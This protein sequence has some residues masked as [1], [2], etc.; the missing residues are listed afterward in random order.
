MS[1]R[2]INPKRDVPL[3]DLMTVFGPD[4]A[5][6]R[7]IPGYQLRDSQLAMAEAVQTALEQ[8][9]HLIAE[10]GT[11][12]GKTFAYLVPAILS[13]KKVLVS[14]GTRNLQDQLIEKDFPLI[15]D[16][17]K[18]PVQAAVLKGRANYLCLYRLEQAQ[19]HQGALWGARDQDLKTIQEWSEWTRSGD[20]SEVRNV[21]EDSPIWPQVTST[22]DNCLGQ[23]CP[24]IHDCHPLKARRKAQDVDVLIVNH[25]L[26]CA[27]WSLKDDGFGELLPDTDVVIIDEAHQLVETA[28]QFLGTALSARQFLLL[29]QDIIR[30][31]EN[32]ALDMPQVIDLAELL[33]QDVRELRTI[34]PKSSHRGQWQ[35]ALAGRNFGTALAQMGE[36]LGEMV[37]CLAQVAARSKGLESC[38]KRAADLKQALVAFQAGTETGWIQW[39][40]CYRTSFVFYRTP[41]DISQAFTDYAFTSAATWIFTSATLSV[42]QRFDFFTRRLGLDDAQAAI[43]ESPFDFRQQALLYLPKGLPEPREAHF[44]REVVNTA[45]P[46]LQASAGRAFFLFTSHRALQEAAGL[47][48]QALDFPLLVQGSQPKQQLLDEFRAHGHAILLG[49][50]SFWEGVDVR[51][52]ALSCVIIDKIPFAS[53]GDP[54]MKARLD[55]MQ[56][57]GMNPFFDYQVPSA[58]L[59]LKQGVGRLIRDAGDRG[60]LMLCDPRLTQKSYGRVFMNSLPKMTITRNVADVAAF[61]AEPDALPT[62]M[63]Q[64]V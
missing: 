41:L 48:E 39:Y 26:L 42:N 18:V 4:G 63:G 7:Q 50:A 8:E 34:L 30:E 12:T 20:V 11:G 40:E 43:W 1:G 23:D 3:T 60:L 19:H 62:A 51:G 28:T 38:W 5:L 45:I 29:A 17:L 13:G 64:P 49:T 22:V 56:A 35:E 52:E 15:R 10:A 27:D 55:Y 46:V 21:A 53:P 24:M 36:R 6:A 33:E 25:H 9:E 47:L 61:F 32:V 16:A 58:A 31:Q 59:M 57:Q 54:V 14:T 37:Q 44:T 2:D